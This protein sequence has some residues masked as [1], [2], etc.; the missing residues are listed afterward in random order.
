MPELLLA[1][2]LYALAVLA[3]HRA[4]AEAR[5]FPPWASNAAGFFLTGGLFALFASLLALS[6]LQTLGVI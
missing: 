5:D 1:A 4:G 2:L 3:F 6:G